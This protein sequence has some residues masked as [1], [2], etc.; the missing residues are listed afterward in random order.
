MLDKNRPDGLF[1]DAVEV[2][3]SRGVANENSAKRGFK[4]Y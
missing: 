1:I 2:I 3:L 4:N